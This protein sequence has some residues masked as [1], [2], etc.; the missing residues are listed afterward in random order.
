MYTFDMFVPDMKT[1]KNLIVSGITGCLLLTSCSNEPKNVTVKSNEDSITITQET[2]PEKEISI[3]DQLKQ[4]KTDITNTLVGT[5]SFTIDG[6]PS[7]IAFSKTR[8]T[9]PNNVEVGE[10]I[11]EITIGNKTRK[12]TTDFTTKDENP[13]L[14]VYTNTILIILSYTGY[15]DKDMENKG[16][17][18]DDGHFVFRLPI[19]ESRASGVWYGEYS[20]TGENHEYE[21]LK[22]K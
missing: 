2:V 19:G 21:L 4:R 16:D 15:E 10:V 18:T 17:F 20:R 3:E 5:W 9:R 13:H 6:T 11:G 1:L 22:Q 7:K 14:D 12:F 8:D